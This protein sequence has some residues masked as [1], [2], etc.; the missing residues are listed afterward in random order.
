MNLI[1]RIFLAPQIIPMN[2]I[3]VALVYPFSDSLS[4]QKKKRARNLVYA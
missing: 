1:H 4:T 3:P 2:L